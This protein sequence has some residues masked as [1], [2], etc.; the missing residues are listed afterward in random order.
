MPMPQLS[1]AYILP[2][3]LVALPLL[4]AIGLVIFGN[5]FAQWMLALRGKFKEDY[6]ALS[7]PSKHGFVYL[8]LVAGFVV[9]VPASVA[10]LFLIG[11]MVDVADNGPINHLLY[12]ARENELRNWLELCSFAANVMVAGVAWFAIRFAKAQSKEAEH[13]RRANVYLEISNRFSSPR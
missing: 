12:R 10:V 8:A 6:K 13:S 3:I 5:R 4:T 7:T 1:A 2:A 11:L 9:F